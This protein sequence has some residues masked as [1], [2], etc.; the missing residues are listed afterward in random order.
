MCVPYLVGQLLLMAKYPSAVISTPMRMLPFTFLKCS[1]AMMA[2]PPI[3]SM[4]SMP[5]KSPMVT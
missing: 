4:G 5:S 1:A 2:R 3:A